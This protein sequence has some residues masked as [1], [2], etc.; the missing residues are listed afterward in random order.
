MSKQFSLALLNYLLLA[1]AAQC[2]SSARFPL[3]LNASLSLGPPSSDGA[4][5][6]LAYRSGGAFPAIFVGLPLNNSVAVVEFRNG[7]LALKTS[8][9]FSYPK[10][11]VVDEVAH[12]SDI[13]F[14]YVLSNSSLV[15]A[16]SLADFH[17]IWSQISTNCS[18]A[19]VQGD[20]LFVA[21]AVGVERFNKLTG[22]LTMSYGT[23]GQMLRPTALVMDYIDGVVHAFAKPRAWKLFN[24]TAASGSTPLEY[25]PYQG[26]LAPEALWPTA[27]FASSE[28]GRLIVS[29]RGDGTRQ[30]PAAIFL[31][32]VSSCYDSTST[33]SNAPL[34]WTLT[35]ASEC[36]SIAVDMN[37]YRV[38][39]TCGSPGV[40]L[41]LEWGDDVLLPLGNVTLPPGASASAWAP[42]FE[43]LLVA[44]PPG[45]AADGSPVSAALSVFRAPVDD[46]NYSQGNSTPSAR[47]AAL[48]PSAS[49]TASAGF[50]PAAGVGAP[51]TALAPGVIAGIVIGS[52]VLLIVLPVCAMIL[53]SNG[54][55]CCASGDEK[56]ADAEEDKGAG[57]AQAAQGASARVFA[58]ENPLR[59][60]SMTVVV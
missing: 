1:A 24:S 30:A 2:A 17:L 48:R 27:G 47:P 13:G 28:F 14:L 31:L 36:D 16:L 29:V 33:C 57:S 40:M 38:Y 49:A 44:T 9:N 10:S 23:T 22:A 18:S 55:Q 19:G 42:A 45:L 51:K 60:A 43:A 4:R 54:R 59:A 21:K 32:N 53:C 50:K 6:S 46:E 3:A 12:G 11:L 20:W 15:S 41:A 58:S 5:V 25:E 8:L 56:G 26:S 7:S 39:V 35:N 37:T 52:I 34:G